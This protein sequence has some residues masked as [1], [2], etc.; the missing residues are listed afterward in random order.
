M[1]ARRSN[2]LCVA[3]K[4]ALATVRTVE[5]NLGR[6]VAGEPREAVLLVGWQP[7]GTALDA[8]GGQDSALDVQ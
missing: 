5:R 8:F 2:L 4:F 3:S 7:A 6:L 1:F